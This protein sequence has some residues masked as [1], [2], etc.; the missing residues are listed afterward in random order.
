MKNYRMTLWFVSRV[1]C[2][3]ALISAVALSVSKH[4]TSNQ[5]VWTH[6]KFEMC[7]H[8]CIQVCMIWLHDSIVMR[9]FQLFAFYSSSM[10]Q[11]FSTQLKTEADSDSNGHL[12]VVKC[13]YCQTFNSKGIIREH[14]I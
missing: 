2:E 8:V 1:A 14:L 3:K 4:F 13:Q 5:C 9:T 12:K 10:C 6:S 7:V 11:C